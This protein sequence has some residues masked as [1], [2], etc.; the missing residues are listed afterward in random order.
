MRA[1]GPI[2]P[3]GASH[4][5]ARCATPGDTATDGLTRAVDTSRGPRH[6]QAS[7]QPGIRSGH[8]P[9]PMT[10]DTGMANPSPSR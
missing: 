1:R 5:A 7:A 3:C 2:P 9:V 10:T 4:L 8:V 6:R